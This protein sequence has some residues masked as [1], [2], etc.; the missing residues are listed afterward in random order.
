MREPQTPTCPYVPCRSMTLAVLAAVGPIGAVVLW[1]QV[2]PATDLIRS[3]YAQLGF[4]A[5]L[6]GGG[7]WAIR[8][9]DKRTLAVEALWRERLA[10]ADARTA[11]AEERARAA[12][13]DGRVVRD[14][15]I[16]QVVPVM[17]M[18]NVR[19]EDLLEGMKQV[20]A[21]VERVVS[22]ALPKQK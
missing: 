4:L 14:A 5:L 10:E 3:G 7:V 16:E 12:E 1:A 8:Q 9:A 6:L 18:Q 15:F 19:S 21:L 2:D 11:A 20:V 13:A 17:T 22:A